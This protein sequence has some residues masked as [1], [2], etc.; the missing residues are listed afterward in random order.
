MARTSHHL[1]GGVALAALLTAFSTGMALAEPLNQALAMAYASNPQLLEQRAYLRSVD[2]GVA[3]A[4]AGWR[5]TLT[6]NADGSSVK[7]SD[8]DAQGVRQRDLWRQERSVGV[9]LT[10]PVFSGF[11]TVNSVDQA[12]HQVD[13]EREHLRS[14]E[15]SV[16]LAAV[17]AYLDVWRDLAVLELNIN[18]EQVLQ[19]QLEASRDR[20][21]VGEITRTDVAQSEAR[22]SRAKADRVTAEGNLQVS[23]ATYQ[24]VIGK[25]PEDISRVPPVDAL[26]PDLPTLLREAVGGN[27]DFKTAD[28][29]VQAKDDAVGVV[30]G[31]LLPSVNLSASAG[32]FNDQTYSDDQMNVYSVGATMTMPLYEAGGTY[33]RLR[34]AKD[35]L[36]QSRK[37]LERVQRQVVETA[38]SSWESLTSARAQIVAYREEV[39]AS[40]IALDGVRREAEVGSRTVLDV[41]DAE[42]E[43]L[44][45]RVSLVKAERNQALASYQVVSAV[46][47]LTAADM[48]LDAPL[49]DP[50]AHYDDAAGAWF[51][52]GV[53]SDDGREGLKP[54][55]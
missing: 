36:A 6:V 38:T 35:Q 3:Q 16:L 18:N 23:R 10:Q 43:L 50:K 1:T 52:T 14:V 22:L 51:G 28:Y 29:T 12:K 21:A 30:R 2:Q 49:Y 8:Y 24:K 25:S 39:R 45:A 20:F 55:K 37:A 33:A 5:P 17:T 9:T 13:A 54:A 41:L 47:R 53:Y 46:G 40:E 7:R 44:D 34:A 42:Q 15:Q 4:L 32:R 19:R 48:G 26:P 11:R 31:E 27:P